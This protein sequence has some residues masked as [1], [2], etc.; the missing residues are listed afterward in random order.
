MS[1][2]PAFQFYPKDWRNNAKLR[3][4][5]P[6]ARGVWVD[7]LCLL[8]DSDEYGVLRWPLKEIAQAAGASMAHVRELVDKGVLKGAERRGEDYIHTPRHAGKAGEPVALVSAGDGPCW[9]S[10]R[11]VKD[12]WLRQRRGIATRFTS[13]DQPEAKAPRRGKRAEADGPYDWSHLRPQIF[14]KTNGHCYHCDKSLG[15][16]GNDPWQV[17]HLV[18]RAK[19]GTNHIDN[20]VPS[21]IP[22]NHTKADTMPHGDL[23]TK[24]RLGEPQGDGPSIASSSATSGSS[25]ANASAAG[26]AAAKT[27]AELTKAELW[28]AGKSLLREAGMPEAQCGSFIGKLAG[29]YKAYP[30]LLLEAVR[31]AVVKQ[32]AD[33]VSFIVATCQRLAGKRQPTSTR[34]AERKQTMAAL[35]GE[36]VMG[37]SH[38]TG[39]VID[40]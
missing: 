22:C 31:T 12:E 24:P 9:Y 17:D 38:A 1:D 35:G 25:E 4:C 40:A 2:R 26:A 14:A 27:P 20:L 6:A 5:S 23:F 10:S 36:F 18:P 19:G 15:R 34:A 13:D 28:A 11:F 21:C 16:I 3:R 33:P 7:L 39:D 30:D 37:E 29:D 32:P 8:H